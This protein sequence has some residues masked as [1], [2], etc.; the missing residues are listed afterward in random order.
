MIARLQITE[1]YTDKPRECHS[2][3]A[4]G[5]VVE[6]EKALKMKITGDKTASLC[7]SDVA[8]SKGKLSGH[9]GGTAF[10]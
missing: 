1:T 10:G 3:Q 5:K 7:N 8:A 4:G 9:V 2:V 6:K